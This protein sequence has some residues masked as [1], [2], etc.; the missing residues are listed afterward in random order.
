MRGTLLFAGLLCT[1]QLLAAQD[2]AKGTVY[3][4]LN[5]NRKLDK[6]EKGIA[7]VSVTNGTQVVQTDSRGGYQLPLGNDN[8]VFVSKPAGYDLPLDDKKQPQFYYIHKPAGSPA[9]KYAG[10]SPTGKVPETIDFPLYAA[11]EQKDFTALVFGDPQAYTLEEMDFFKKGIVEEAKLN[12]GPV[13]G[14]SLGD[15]V[16]DDLSLHKPYIKTIAELGIPWFNVMGNHDMNYD[17]SADSLS[18]EGFEAAFGPNNYSFNYGDVHFVVLDDILY[19]NPRTGKG[20]LGGFRND[21]LEWIAND[22]KFVPKDK[23]IV[24]AF[25]IPLYHEQSDVFRNEDRQRLF[26]LLEPFPNTLSLSAHTHYQTQ[27]FYK[28][29]D[30]WK[31][32]KP[33]HEYNVGTTSGDWY[34]GTFNKQGV[35]G[36]TM[37]DGTPKGY[38]FL[39]IKGNKYDFDYKVAG[40]KP[41][42][43]INLFGT[44][45]VARKYVSRHPVYANFFI[46]RKDDLVEYRIN[47]GAWKPMNYTSDIDPHY[48]MNLYQYDSA[49]SLQEGRRP[50]DPVR[51]SH[52][53]RVNLP[54]LDVGTHTL[55][56]RATDMFGRKHSQQ[57]Q[58]QV[59]EIKPE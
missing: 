30:G 3:N 10:V 11:K 18:D 45:V 27:L 48:T 51:S 50:S 33:H 46:G 21:Q 25:H 14:L 39:N 35:P 40:E 16:G 24:L 44:D 13:F 52:L 53:W 32:A 56:V 58:I 9:L 34:S 43:Q 15:L 31:Q 36:S 20:Y 28:A 2:V 5:G 26:D 29:E 49:K 54:K 7:G 19:P 41:E 59:V 12:K 37:R 1:S 6:N 57:K 22:L 17:V 42:Y 4:D 55:E 47:G 38:M 8:I 23:L